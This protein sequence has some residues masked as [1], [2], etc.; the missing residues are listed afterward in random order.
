MGT[1]CSWAHLH[2]QH[3]LW[4][5]C[6]D[7]ARLLQHCQWRK[8]AAKCLDAP[9]G[10]AVLEQGVWHRYEPSAACT[11]RVGPMYVILAAEKLSMVGGNMRVPVWS[12][13]DMPEKGNTHFIQ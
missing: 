3:V 6:M 5:Q 13:W 1:R 12:V 7:R 9:L 10:S 4:R 2:A 8:T 11:T